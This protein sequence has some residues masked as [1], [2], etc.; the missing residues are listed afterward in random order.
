M[1]RK[2][3]MASVSLNFALLFLT[4]FVFVPWLLEVLRPLKIELPAAVLW[5]I[6]ASDF[7]QSPWG[8]G[9]VM[10]GMLMGLLWF[11]AAMKRA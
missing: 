4:L 7:V 8:F 2:L 5:M 6:Y 9:L 1:V 10:S 11:K 3:A